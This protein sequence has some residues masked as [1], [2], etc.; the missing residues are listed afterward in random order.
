MARTKVTPHKGEKDDRRQVRMRAEM[1]AQSQPQR[2]PTLVD[3]PAPAQE[4]PPD[5]DK[6]RRKVAEV[7]W[8]EEAGRLPQLSIS[9]QLA[10]MATEAGPSMLGGKE[11]ARKK[12]YPT[13]GEKAPRKEFLKAGVIK[14]T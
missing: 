2:P 3:P 8:F 7:E 11:P 13:V 5:Q 10:Q 4:T 12:F 9:Q 6:I 1:Y 14:K